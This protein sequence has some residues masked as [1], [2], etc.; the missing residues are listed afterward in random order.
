MTIPTDRK[1]VESEIMHCWLEDELLIFWEKP[2]RATIE[3]ISRHRELV[4]ELTEGRRLPLL[5][6]LKET[7]RPDTETRLEAAKGLV[8]H[9]IAIALISS[10]ELAQDTIR[11][12]YLDQSDIPV[13]NFTDDWAA[14]RWLKQFKPE[15]VLA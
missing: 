14:K 10:P 4:S 12:F 15:P 2:V 8:K 1:T 5:I 13:K 6:Y 3:N 9:Y 7:P 11:L